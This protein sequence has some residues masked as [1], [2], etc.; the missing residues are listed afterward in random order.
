MNTYMHVV[1]K[2]VLEDIYEVG[3]QCGWAIDD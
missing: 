2:Q 1:W 3:Q